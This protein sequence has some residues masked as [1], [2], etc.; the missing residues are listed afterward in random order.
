MDLTTLHVNVIATRSRQSPD[1][2]DSAKPNWAWS[3]SRGLWH[4]TGIPSRGAYLGLHR[5]WLRISAR[6]RA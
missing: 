5:Y 6:Y 1:L 3:L 2:R 4:R